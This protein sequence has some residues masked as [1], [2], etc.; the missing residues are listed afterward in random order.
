MIF[1]DSIN[2]KIKFYSLSVFMGFVFR[3]TTRDAGWRLCNQLGRYAF[4]KEPLFS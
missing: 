3:H 2:C 1:I 4:E